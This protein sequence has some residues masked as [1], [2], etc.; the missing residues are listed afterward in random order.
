MLFDINRYKFSTFIKH[1][2]ALL[3]LAVPTLLAQLAQVGTGF[4]DTVMAGGASKDDLAAV[5]LGNSLFVT[6]YVSLMG[7]MTAINPILSQAFGALGAQTDKRHI[8][9]IGRQGL[10]LGVLLGVLGM[11]TMWALI[12]FFQSS[13]NLSAYGLK[14]AG[15]YIYYIGYAMPAAIIHRALHAYAL[16]LERPNIITAASFVCFFFKHSFKLCVCLWRMGHAKAWRSRVWFGDCDC[17]LG[18]CGDIV[19]VCCQ[20]QLF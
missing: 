7:V 17:I 10:Y 16:S 12:D 13:F 14:T 3:L 19:G 4:V 8:G 9:E 20:K 2:H 5:A 15:E 18:E 1:T 11:L 6:I